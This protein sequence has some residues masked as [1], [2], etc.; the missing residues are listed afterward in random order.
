[1]KTTHEINIYGDI[2]PF[3]YWNDDSEY[4]RSDL[5]TSIDSL[6]LKEGDELI[7]NIHTFGGCTTTAFS[8]YNKLLRVKTEKKITL[9]SRADGFCASSGVIILLAADK[10][11]GSKYL[12]PFVH[13]AWLWVDAV[14]KNEAK[15]AYEV[16]ENVD[17]EIAELYAERTSITKDKAI[18]LMNESR[19]VTLDECLDYGFY[20]EIENI[21]SSENSLIFNS[22]R[23]LNTKSRTI[24]KKNM[25]KE[26][27]TKKEADKKFNSLGETLNKIMN[28]L[29]GKESTKAL[30]VQDAN[31]TEIDFPDVETDAEPQVGDKANI[32]GNPADGEYVMPSGD[33]Y[34]FVSGELTEIKTETEED[35]SEE[36]EALKADNETLKAE[37]LKLKGDVDAA[38]DSIKNLQVVIEDVK[39]EVSSSFNYKPEIDGNKKPEGDGEK[40]RNLFKKD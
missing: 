13:N 20:T 27:L 1:M 39:K 15:K 24:N 21:Y 22:L 31:G 33:T 25:S 37:N 6:D 23:I 34:V 8:I 17:N 32:D 14:D 35:D 9:T 4:D 10:R 16:L 38:I 3:K 40:T 7:Y 2:V 26:V 19:D 36:V 5:N 18:E 11:I 30:L 28:K 12:K 29:T